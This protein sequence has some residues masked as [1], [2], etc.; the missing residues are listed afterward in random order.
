MAAALA[1]VT[2][3]APAAAQVPKQGGILTYMIPADGP[4]SLDGHRETTYAT[5]H[6]AAPFYSTLIRVNPENPSSTTDFVCDLC[7]AMPQPRDDGKTYVFKIRADVKFHD[8][9][10]LTATDVAASWNAIIHPPEGVSSARESFYVMVDTVQAP[11]PTTVGRWSSG[12]CRPRPAISWSR[13]SA[14]RLWCRRAIG[15]AATSS[16]P[17]TRRSRSTM[18]E[19]AGRCCWRSTNGMGRRHSPRSPTSAPWAALSS[20][21]RR[22]RQPR[23]SCSGSPGSGRTL[24]NRAPRPSAS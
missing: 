4:P 11:D 12:A 7:T 16:P 2:A 10:R 21:A 19:Y 1:A 22:W 18:F 8:G 24:R 20:R 6:T 23:R 5:V 13:S 14:T 17:I 15:T 9:S 3:A